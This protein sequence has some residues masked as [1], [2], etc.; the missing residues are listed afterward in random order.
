MAMFVSNANA[1]YHE[2]YR[3]PEKLRK[4]LQN[5]LKAPANAARARFFTFQSRVP[6]ANCATDRNQRR[7][8]S[9]TY[10]SALSCYVR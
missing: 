1:A 4:K 6:L 7:R 9:M 3:K 2:S 10:T 8:N 5:F